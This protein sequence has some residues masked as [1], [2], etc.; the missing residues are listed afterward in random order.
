MV[1]LMYET[2]HSNAPARSRRFLPGLSLGAL[3]RLRKLTLR[4]YA[5]HKSLLDDLQPQVRTLPGL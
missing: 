1:N 3:T 2:G 4:G 5:S